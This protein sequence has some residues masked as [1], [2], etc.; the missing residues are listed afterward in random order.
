MDNYLC[1]GIDYTYT[2]NPQMK[3]YAASKLKLAIIIYNT[4]DIVTFSGVQSKFTIHYAY[5]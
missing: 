1:F 5:S 3:L 4:V 2:Y